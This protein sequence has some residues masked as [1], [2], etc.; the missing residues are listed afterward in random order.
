MVCLIPGALRG[1]TASWH[2]ERRCVN[3]TAMTSHE[4]QRQSMNLPDPDSSW[5]TPRYDIGLKSAVNSA[6]MYPYYEEDALICYNIAPFWSADQ[7]THASD[8]GSQMESVVRLGHVAMASAL[9]TTER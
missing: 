5:P 4:R 8:A 6:S 7:S 3:L 1:F 2:P 9:Y